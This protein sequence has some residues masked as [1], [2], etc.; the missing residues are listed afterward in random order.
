MGLTDKESEVYD[1]IVDYMVEHG[2]APTVREICDMAGFEST[3]TGFKYLHRLCEKKVI[4]SD[5]KPRAIRL[6]GYRLVKER[7]HDRYTTGR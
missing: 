6:I 4:W 7:E 5:G 1:A 3:S 2:Y